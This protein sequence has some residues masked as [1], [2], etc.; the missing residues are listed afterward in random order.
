MRPE[1]YPG[2]RLEQLRHI[3]YIYAVCP[4]RKVT[5]SNLFIRKRY[6]VLF[7]ILIFTVLVTKLVQFTLYIAFLKMPSVT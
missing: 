2:A 7:L 4:R 5:V 1:A 6:Y 3:I